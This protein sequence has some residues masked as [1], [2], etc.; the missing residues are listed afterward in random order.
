MVKFDPVRWRYGMSPHALTDR[1]RIKFSEPEKRPLTKFQ[2][3]LLAVGVTLCVIGLTL[4]GMLWR[5][6]QGG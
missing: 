4:A 5:L 2:K 6:T 1:Q 3:A